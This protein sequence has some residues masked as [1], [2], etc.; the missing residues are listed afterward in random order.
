MRREEEAS[1]EELEGK[2]EEWGKGEEE[3]ELYRDS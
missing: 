2:E 1:R 3:V